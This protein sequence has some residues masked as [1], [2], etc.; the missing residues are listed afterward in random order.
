MQCHKV[1]L[2]DCTLCRILLL[3]LSFDIS[4]ITCYINRMAFLQNSFKQ[5]WLKWNIPWKPLNAWWNPLSLVC[6]SPVLSV[7]A[8]YMGYHCTIKKWQWG[9]LY[10]Q[11]E[12]LFPFFMMINNYCD[13]TMT[14]TDWNVPQQWTTK[15]CS[16]QVPCAFSKIVSQL[17]QQKY[18]HLFMRDFENCNCLVCNMQRKRPSKSCDCE[19]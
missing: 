10:H 2:F 13:V 14:L 3:D 7:L 1:Y 17:A 9:V 5:N 16:E 11:K 18:D 4:C 15:L 8:F 12:Q 6:E 19:Q